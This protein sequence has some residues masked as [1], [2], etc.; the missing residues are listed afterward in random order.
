MKL[1]VQKKSNLIW[2]VV[3]FTQDKLGTLAWCIQHDLQI[4]PR[5]WTEWFSKHFSKQFFAVEAHLFVPSFTQK[6]SKRGCSVVIRVS[7]SW[8]LDSRWV[9]NCQNKKWM[10]EQEK[11]F[12]R[13]P[14][15]WGEKN[16]GNEV[17]LRNMYLGRRNILCTGTRK[18]T[19][20]LKRL[21]LLFKDAVGVAKPKVVVITSTPGHFGLEFSSP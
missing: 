5:I 2:I 16:F 8:K 6:V 12:K 1:L 4:P 9:Y 20:K 7:P 17:A 11:S 18:N 3:L 21:H 10:N 19:E 13:W 15:I 14:H